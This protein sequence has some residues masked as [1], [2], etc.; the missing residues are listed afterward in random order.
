MKNLP[1]NLIIEKNKIAST[2]PWIVLLEIKVSDTEILRICNN[3]EDITFQSNTYYAM[4]FDISAT[5]SNAKGEI[6]TVTLQVSNV[7][8]MLQPYIEQYAGGVGMQVKL[9]VVN[10]SYLSENYSELEMVFDILATEADANWVYFTLGTPNPLRRRFPQYRYIAEHCQWNF[11]SAECGYTGAAT[12]C[13]RTFE[14]CRLLGNTKKFGG[15][16]GL[17]GG[18]L[19]IV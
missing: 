2:S 17:S 6:P 18:Y 11:K 5:Q 7:S 3:T 15:Y 10:A 4:P 16:K 14:W 13:K 8:R 12:E 1:A 19:R 9:I